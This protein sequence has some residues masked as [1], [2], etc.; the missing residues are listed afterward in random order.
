M[1]KKFKRIRNK[2]GDIYKILSSKHRK[3]QIQEIYITEI[4]YRKIKG[5]NFHQKATSNLIVI[6]G[7]VEFKITKDFLHFKKIVLEGRDDKFLLIKPK[8]WFCFKGISKKNKI[9][10][11]SNFKHNKN[12][13]KKKLIKI[14]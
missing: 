12:E 3:D 7:K 13:I 14:N 11:F 1:I 5:W 4:N 6:L 8:I 9:L 2:L 10:N